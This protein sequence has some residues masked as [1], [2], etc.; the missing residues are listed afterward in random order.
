MLRVRTVDRLQGL[1]LGLA[2]GRTIER[3]LTDRLQGPV[4][5]LG[6]AEAAWVGSCWTPLTAERTS[7]LF[8]DWSAISRPACGRQ[9]RLCVVSVGGSLCRLA[10][11]DL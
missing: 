2:D 9:D 4:L 7:V 6:S 5:L 11:C 3:D 1:R 8:A 10:A